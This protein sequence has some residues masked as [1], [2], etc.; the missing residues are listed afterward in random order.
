MFSKMPV[1]L[2]FMKKNWPFHPEHRLLISLKLLDIFSACIHANS[3]ISS[4]YFHLYSACMELAWQSCNGG[5]T[6]PAPA[7]PAANVFHYSV[8]E[9]IVETWK[10]KC[11][12]S[13]AALSLTASG[14]KPLGQVICTTSIPEEPE[15]TRL[16]GDEPSL[17]IHTVAWAHHLYLHSSS[18]KPLCSVNYVYYPSY[19]PIQP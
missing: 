10:S 9:N 17:S 5:I 7:V 3:S 1:Y 6:F 13:K 11:C 15:S 18:I 4:P 14:H 19:R 16:T 12:P 2:G 8:S